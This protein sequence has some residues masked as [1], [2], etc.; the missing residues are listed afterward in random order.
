MTDGEFLIYHNKKENWNETATTFGIRVSWFRSELL[1]VITL[2]ATVMVAFSGA[3][4]FKS[5]MVPLSLLWHRKTCQSELSP[6]LLA[7]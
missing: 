2:L 6:A 3:I 1:I 5:Q 7:A 4:G